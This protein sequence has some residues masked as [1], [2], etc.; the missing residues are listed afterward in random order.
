MR[1]HIIFRYTGFV[2]LFDSAFLFISAGI[3]ALHPDSALLPLLYSATLAALFGIF[4]LIFVAPAPDISNREGFIIVISS[5]LLTCLIG[6]M[7]YILWGG[8]FSLANAWF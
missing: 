7:P 6:V 8:E 4:P 1:P 5:W 2:F 3:S